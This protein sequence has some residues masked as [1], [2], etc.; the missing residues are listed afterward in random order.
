MDLI[1]AVIRLLASTFA[2][3][4]AVLRLL[5]AGRGGT[6]NKNDR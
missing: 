4:A 1:T 2:L 5:P 3:I 6:D